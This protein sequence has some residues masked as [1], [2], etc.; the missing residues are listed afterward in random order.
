MRNVL[1]NRLLEEW[2]NNHISENGNGLFY[3]NAG[4]VIYYA[5]MAKR[6]PD[7]DKMYHRVLKALIDSVPDNINV[8]LK[9]GAL[10]I[11]VSLSFA[12]YWYEKQTSDIVLEDLDA[13]IYRKVPDIISAVK[14]NKSSDL[15]NHINRLTLS[16]V[17]WYYSLRLLWGVST[18]FLNRLFTQK[19]MALV[20]VVYDEIDSANE[21]DS[22]FMRF[23][24]RK[25]LLIFVD[26]II[27]LYRVGIYQKRILH[28]LNEMSYKVAL[29]IPVL[30][31]NRLSLFYL[32]LSACRY[33]ENLNVL[34]KECCNMLEHNI[35]EQVIFS[36]ELR[37]RDV[38]FSNGF[39]GVFLLMLLCNNLLGK[40][41]FQVDAERYRRRVS[42]SGIIREFHSNM[43]MQG[44]NGAFGMNL[45]YNFLI[46][47]K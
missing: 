32:S 1:Y 36:E 26:S 33:I 28:I 12:N 3:G 43:E 14:E 13:L 8:F 37:H 40:K 22:D 21:T 16:D 6:Y 44:L 29:N 24:L 42:E 5:C 10:G 47:M 41:I 11:G 9:D 2:V 15:L 31:S 25:P 45:L 20:E 30:H 19:A 39:S 35:S 4:L 17:L 18:P 23:T 7:Y 46:N 27:R 34:W 38:C